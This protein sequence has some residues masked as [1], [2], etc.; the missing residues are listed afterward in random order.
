MNIWLDD[1]V[2]VK[3]ELNDEWQANKGLEE[4][5]IGADL[6]DSLIKDEFLQN[7][8]N[9]HDERLFCKKGI[10]FLMIFKSIKYLLKKEG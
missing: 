2:D 6:R 4:V 8:R 10:F 9:E 3:S 7:Y 5:Y 1:E